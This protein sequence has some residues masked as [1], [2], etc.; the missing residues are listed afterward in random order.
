[1]T[2]VNLFLND[3]WSKRAALTRAALPVQMPALLER[4]EGQLFAGL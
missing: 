3:E 4:A 1:M 2:V